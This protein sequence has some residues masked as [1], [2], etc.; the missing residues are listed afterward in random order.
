MYKTVSQLSH[1]YSVALGLFSRGALAT[2]IFF[3]VV[4]EE[5]MKFLC[6]SR[7]KGDKHSDISHSGQVQ[8]AAYVSW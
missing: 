6:C 2:S 5:H 4:L 7:S 3:S 1:L 8:G